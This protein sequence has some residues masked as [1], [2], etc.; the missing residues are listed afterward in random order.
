MNQYLNKTKPFKLPSLGKFIS[1]RPEFIYYICTMF[2]MCIKTR[3]F[4]THGHI[5]WIIEQERISQGCKLCKRKMVG[6]FGLLTAI[7]TLLVNH[8]LKWEREFWKPNVAKLV[9]EYCKIV[10]QELIVWPSLLL[11]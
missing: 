10:Q 4:T 6:G 8:K 5:K 11:F 2:A 3:A 1:S 9:L 7:I